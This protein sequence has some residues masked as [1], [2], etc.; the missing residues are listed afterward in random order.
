MPSVPPPPDSS[1]VPHASVL[2]E[3]LVSGLD[4]RAGDVVVDAT[5]GAGGHSEAILE[6]TDATVIG[7]DRDATALEIARRR[8]A[9]FGDRV[10]FVKG[11]FGDIEAVLAGWAWF[12]QQDPRRRRRQL[13]ADRHGEPRDELP[14]GRSARHADGRRR[15]RDRARADRTPR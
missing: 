13:D 3:E 14:P 10:R 15:G 8:L 9:R 11:R 5:L 6:R 7:L 12:T 2:L 1:R 4:L